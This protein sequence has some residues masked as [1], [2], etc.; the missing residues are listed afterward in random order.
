MKQLNKQDPAIK[1][2]IKTQ[3]DDYLEFP[4]VKIINKSNKIEFFVNR[5][6]TQTDNCIKQTA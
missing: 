4:D 2:T 1:F 6:N 3:I 5:K